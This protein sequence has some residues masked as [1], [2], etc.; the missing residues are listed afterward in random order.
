MKILYKHPVLRFSG[1]MIIS[2]IPLLLSLPYVMLPQTRIMICW[3]AF[4]LCYLILS[5][6]T[7][8]YEDTTGIKHT[9]KNLDSSHNFIFAVLFIATIFSVYIVL[10]LVKSEE[11][12]KKDKGIVETISF[13]GIF[14][15]WMLLHTNYSFHYA[16]LY[17]G[18][19]KKITDSKPGL[20]FP[21]DK[22]PD[23]MDFA[24]FSFV[25]GMTFQ[26]SDVIIN[27]QQIRKIVLIHS[28]LSFIFNVVIIAL[29][30]NA[31]VNI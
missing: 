11:V 14:F 17:Y 3:D 29:C 28:L 21:G 12:L 16:H 13:L 20:Y 8:R 1:A 7:F 30:V 24:Y 19:G 31:V 4:V 22:D 5:W 26:V 2:F 10:S 25:I 23:Y 27:S 15:S 6:M 18:M 9:A